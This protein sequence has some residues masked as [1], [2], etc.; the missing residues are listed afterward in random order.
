MPDEILKPLTRKE[1]RFV[2]IYLKNGFNGTQAVKKAGFN[3]NSASARVTASRLLSKANVKKYIE[4]KKKEVDDKDILDAT[5]VLRELSIIARANISDF[6][7]IDKDTGAIQA[8][9]FEDMPENMSRAIETV[10]EDRAIKGNEDGTSTTVYDKIKFKCH[11]KVKALELLGNYRELWKDKK[12]VTGADGQPLLG[13][14]IELI[15]CFDD[16]NA[17]EPD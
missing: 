2:H 11:S 3:K 15:V 1:E 12:E 10:S 9:G 13:S 16:P 4:Q 17:K 8:K 7:T 5:E 14:N 6:I